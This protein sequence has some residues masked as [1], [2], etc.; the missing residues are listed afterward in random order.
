[1]HRKMTPNRL[2]RHGLDEKKKTS[3]QQC[4]KSKNR[5]KKVWGF[6]RPM[7]VLAKKE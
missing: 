2:A 5:V 1:M 3:G 6:Q 4:K 7:L